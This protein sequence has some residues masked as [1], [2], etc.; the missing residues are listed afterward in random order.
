MTVHVLHA[1]DGYLYLIRQV[2]A[3]DARLAAGTSLAAYYTAS[4]Q[5]PGR[6]AGTGA[7]RIGVAGAVTEA[8]MKSLFGDGQHPDAD[9]IQAQLVEN[10]LSTAEATQA[11]RLGRRFPHYEP[12]TRV[13]DLAHDSYQKKEQELDRPLTD[14][15]KLT[16]RQE[17]TNQVFQRRTGRS[18]VDP[19]ELGNLGEVDPASA[20]REAVA[21]Y[22]LAFTPVKSVATL[23][24]LASEP[25]RQQIF[26]AHEAAVADSLAW[27]EQ[28]VA[29]TRAGA[30]GQAQ[31]DTQGVIAAQ[32]HHW[33][34]RAGDPDLHTHVAI[35]NK[36]QGPDGKWRSLDGRTIFAAAVS[37]SER[38]NTRIEDELRSRLG[39][40]FAERSS[41][42]AARDGR[43]PVREIVGLPTELLNTFSKRRHG[44]EQQYQDLLAAYRRDHCRDPNSTTRHALYQQATLHERPEKPRRQSLQQMVDGWRAE[45]EQI[46]GTPAV[47]RAV[48]NLTLHRT[49]EHRVLDVGRLADET[50]AALTASRA[51]WNEHHLRA[52]AQRR[53]RSYATADRDQLVE[54]VVAAAVDPRRSVRIT[55]PR[56]LQEP[57]ELRRRNGESVFHEHGSTIY[58]THTVLEA[59]RRIADAGRER[60]AHRLDP[61]IITAVLAQAAS[62]GRA[63]NEGQAALVRAFCCSGRRVQLGLAPAGTGKTTAMK[64]VTDAWRAGGKPVV[65]LA[66]SAAAAD[67]LG[68][69]LGVSA[70]TLAKFDHDQ[71]AIK[72]DTLILVDEAGM[73]GTMIL[74]RLVAQARFAGAVV[75]LVGDD[76]QL[77][78]IEAGGVLRHL[79]HDVGAIRVHE[80]L[81]F[82]D[83]AEAEAT[84]KV[85]RGDPTAADHYLTKERVVAGTDATMTDAAYAA[86]L[87]DTRAGRDALL[88][89]PSTSTVDDLNTQA[90]ADLVLD[91]KVAVDGVP[92]H[93]GTVAGVG[94]RV[95]TRRNERRNTVN[96]GKDW[97]KNGDGW[98]VTAVY[99]DGSLTVQHRRHHGH[100]TLPGDYVAQHVELDYARTVRRSQGL[101]VDHAHLVVDPQ[102]TRP[103]FYVGVSRARHDTH[104]YVPLMTDPGPDHRP[105]M[106]GSARDVL[107]QVITRSAA[108]PSA[109]EAV[110]TAVDTLGDLRRMSAEYE[111]ALDVRVGDRHRLV[112]E[113]AHPGITADRAW[114][115]VARQLHIAEGLGHQPAAII[116]KADRLGDYTDAT[117]EARVLAY[118]LDLLNHEQAGDPKVPTWLAAAPPTTTDSP[119]DPRWACYLDARHAEMAE[120]ITTLGIEA[121]G[122]RATWLAEIGRCDGR[123]AAIRNVVAYRAVYNQTGDDALG[124]EPDLAGRQHEAWTAVR[125]AINRSHADDTAASAN[126]GAPNAVRFL[127]LLNQDEATRGNGDSYG[128]H[129]GTSRGGPTRGR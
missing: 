42:R 39:V 18:A 20:R 75:R 113:T 25:V 97:V 48:E 86:W 29:F 69:E 108:Q 70:D 112:A 5:P 114:P 37:V 87:A 79:E 52:E 62:S 3:H 11:T 72:Q 93:N 98:T 119:T 8:Q 129:P 82:T 107:T 59:E 27:F 116:A 16:A 17:A 45:A 38:Y 12:A 57:V 6:W 68:Q 83:P 46:L 101:T 94:D 43:R 4:G 118:R 85:R 35:S 88:L 50:V 109:H 81:R 76:Q 99:D 96:A 123:A 110:K 65:A 41:G 21:G 122:E 89:A 91:G 23:W 32:F 128:D 121:R 71:P 9:R 104:L 66:P 44:I 58:T 30:H 61:A 31:V 49:Q 67:V 34:S 78:A 90:R 73:A 22:D 74:D 54:S 1:A 63:L 84:L 92:L 102:M 95:A 126:R 124:P 60:G 80:V 10:G 127:A 15:E 13:T 53:T 77:A 47:A 111:H 106:A 103:E 120:R 56:T 26:D 40:E 2:A 28:N 117:S 14:E 55:L 64:A 36:V 100:T 51:T 105:E 125:R 19:V 33:D 115:A 7:S 24:G